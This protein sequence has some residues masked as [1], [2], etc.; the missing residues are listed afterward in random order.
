MDKLEVVTELRLRREACEQP[1]RKALTA[2]LEQCCPRPTHIS[3]NRLFRWETRLQ[4]PSPY[5]AN[6]LCAYFDVAS[7]AVLGLGHTR[8]ARHNWTWGTKQERRAE[9]HRRKLIADGAKFV[10]AGLLPVG[11]LV[12]MAQRLGGAP[13][14]GTAEVQ[15]AERVATHLASEYLASPTPETVRAAVAHA[16]TLTDR[17]VH[18][19]MYSPT[20]RA[21][22]AAV[23][24][25]AA[26]LAGYT[27]VE[28][29]RI[30]EGRSWFHHALTLAREAGD[31][32]LEALVRT[33][34]AWTAAP[35]K[36]LPK[37]GAWA[38]SLEGLQAAAELDPH[39]PAAARAYVHSYLA[40]ELAGGGDDAHSGHALESALTAA[41][42]VG[43]G[44]P[45]W[46][47]WSEHANLSGW[48]GARM[49]VHTGLRHLYLGCCRDAVPLFEEALAGT[50]APIRRAW[51]HADLLGTA[52]GL[53]E[54]ERARAEALAA[55][56]EA[57]A[58]GLGLIRRQLGDMR[59][60]FPSDWPAWATAELDERLAAAREDG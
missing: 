22:L 59:Q 24:A 6:A 27:H 42:Q 9:V 40:R 11:Q 57:D 16:C 15:A 49:T 19:D 44:D 21:R 48:D 12:A 10:G 14:L 32:R 31:R 43:R 47:Y 7:V 28:A 2:R 30:T 1:L 4:E 25:D 3:E 5:Y 23:A 26:S 54:P 38:E 37:P 58:H 52:V 34:I 13:S 39:L 18:A 50:A 33:S 29:G 46:G 41:G 8:E 53:D 60:G 51:V 35:T 20:D 17:L 56:D 36:L 45:G 55:L